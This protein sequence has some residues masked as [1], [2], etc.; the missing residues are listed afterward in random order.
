MGNYPDDFKSLCRRAMRMRHSPEQL[1]IFQQ[2]ISLADAHG[3]EEHGYMA[4]Q[5]AMNAATFSGHDDI[6]RE[7][8]N[9]C[10]ACF[11]RNPD[12][13]EAG[14]LLWKY[15]WAIAQMASI[16]AYPRQQVLD[17]LADFTRRV[18]P[19]DLHPRH[20]RTTAYLKMC[21][22]MDFGE[23]A[24]AAKAWRFWRDELRDD[25]SDCPACE[26]HR[27]VCL[28]SQLGQYDECV[29]AAERL[30]AGKLRCTEVPA[31]TYGH[32]LIP[33]LKAGMPDR[34]ARLHVKGYK[35]TRH[36]PSFVLSWGHHLGF[37][38]LT[39][40]LDRGQDIFQQHLEAV[41]ASPRPDH[42]QCFFAGAELLM[43]R[44]AGQRSVQ[45]TLPQSFPPYRADGV[46]SPSELARWLAA[47]VDRFDATM[48]QRNGN[49]SRAAASAI[50]RSMLQCT[51]PV[52]LPLGWFAWL[53]GA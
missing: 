14:V 52:K 36:N 6:F 41:M 35:A 13:Y 34:A 21:V 42:C 50:V 33:L 10:L 28:L 48:D 25:L 32:T 7:M 38:A 2:A 4:R 26:L 37:A 49:T 31:E 3:N 12:R 9:W 51:G 45:L 44:L 22:E 53:F 5:E 23:Y 15:K 16:P 18:D 30:F 17:A 39:H 1:A 47:E 40:N 11:D 27:V 19:P 29:E 24:A 43:S 8:F 20:P 46:Y